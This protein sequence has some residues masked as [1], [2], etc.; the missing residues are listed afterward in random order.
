MRQ[1]AD[2]LSEVRAANIIVPDRTPKVLYTCSFRTVDISFGILVTL[3]VFSLQYFLEA[4]L[5]TEYFNMIIYT[6]SYYMSVGSTL[7]SWNHP[8]HSGKFYKSWNENYYSR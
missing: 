6:L 5:Y 4:I 8:H 2:F 7:N 3:F 1:I